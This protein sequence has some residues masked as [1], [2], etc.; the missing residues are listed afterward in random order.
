MKKLKLKALRAAA[1]KRLRKKGFART[2]AGYLPPGVSREDIIKAA[3]F[4][5]ILKMNK[6]IKPPSDPKIGI[7]PLTPSGGVN[8]GFTQPMLAPKK[9]TLLRPK[10]YNNVM[11]IGVESENDSSIF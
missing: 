7:S 8:V 4:R 2:R 3:K 11:D 10:I 9:G 1:N 5:K 6:R